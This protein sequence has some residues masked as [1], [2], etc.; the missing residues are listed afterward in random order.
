M[1]ARDAPVVVG[2]KDMATDDDT[3]R[4]AAREAASTGRPLHV[5]HAFE[6][7]LFMSRD[8][9]GDDRELAERMVGEA[10]DLA[11]AERAGLTVTSAVVDGDPI[12]VLLRAAADAALLVLGGR[13]LAQVGHDP[14][15]SVSI[16]VAARSARPVLF[17]CGDE[18]P[19]PVVVGVDG[20]ADSTVGLGAAFDEARRRHTDV[21]VLHAEGVRCRAEGGDDRSTAPA[22]HRVVDRPADEALIAESGAAQLVVVGAQ[23]DR[24]SLLGPVT[25]AV[26]R[27]AHCPVLVTR[28]GSAA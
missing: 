15:A 10:V 12:R 24:P 4:L 14:T 2:V 17:A 9:Y 6:W 26:L 13:G 3:V 25:Q 19:G 23:G 28:A 5:V 8:P 27:H 18:H 16:Q 11:R 7:P 1:A 20:S 22:E 21:V